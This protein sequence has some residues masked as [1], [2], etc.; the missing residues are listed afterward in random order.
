MQSLAFALLEKIGSL[1][2]YIVLGFI[3]VRFKVLKYEDSKALSAF[4]L[5]FVT[6]CAMLDAFQYEY[7]PAKLM[8]MGIALLGALVVCVVFAVLIALLKK[9]LKLSDVDSLSLIYPNAG[10]FMLPL[11]SMALGGDWVIYCCPTFMVMNLLMF[12]HGKSVMSRAKGFSWDMILKNVV[13]ITSLIGF[14]MFLCNFKFPGM[15]GGVVT[16]FGRMMGPIYMFVVGMIIGNADLKAV[17]LNKRAYLICLG[18]LVIMPIAAMLVICLC[19][20]LRLHPDAANIL[21]IVVLT[22]GAP[23]AVMVTQF[24]Q[25]YRSTEEAAFAGSVNIISSLLCLFTIPVLARLYELLTA[26][27]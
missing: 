23:A 8:G 24:A 11:I 1:S 21:L 2:I 4:A 13:I 9:P 26:A 14:V 3:A 17:F 7:S 5:Y 15:I 16:D 20:L 10:N 22:A 6:P 25:M 18:R 19:G 27:L 12:T